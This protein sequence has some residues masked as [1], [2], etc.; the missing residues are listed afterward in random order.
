MRDAY[1]AG[2]RGQLEVGAT[3]DELKE[4]ATPIICIEAIEL[5]LDI[6]AA[7]GVADD[8]E[9]NTINVIAR[10]LEV[11]LDRFG[12]LKDKRLL[13]LPAGVAGNVDLRA[14]LSIEAEWDSD[15]I[16]THLNR[17]YAQWNSRAESL[18]DAERRNQAEEMLNHI[19]RARETFL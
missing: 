17:L 4:F 13:T 12:E 5:C 10:R 9:L 1:T 11:D 18:Q 6:M 14:L 16:R 2:V 15:Q 3:V 19:A 7:D 8:N